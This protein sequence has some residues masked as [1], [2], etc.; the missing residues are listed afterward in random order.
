MRHIQLV[1]AG[2]VMQKFHNLNG[3]VQLPVRFYEIRGRESQRVATLA[4]ELLAMA[5]GDQTAPLRGELDARWRIVESSFATGLGSSLNNQGVTEDLQRNVITDKLRLPSRRRM[6]SRGRLPTQPLPDL[7]RLPGPADA[8]GSRPRLPF[9]L[10]TRRVALGWPDLDLGS[11][12]NLAPA[13]AAC[14]ARQ[15][16]VRRPEPNCN[17]WRRGTPPSCGPRIR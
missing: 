5:G 11:I 9:S 6:G 4:P 8:R 14:N 13:H 1:L 3:G 12:W 2:M 16:N 15:S 7:R 10:M 17:A